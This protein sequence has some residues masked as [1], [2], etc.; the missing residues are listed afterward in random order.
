MLI[1]DEAMSSV[2]LNSELYIQKALKKLTEGRTCFIIAHRLSTIHNA[3]MI[4]VVDGGGIV[5]SGSHRELM[6]K[7]GLY[8]RMYES[9]ATL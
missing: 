5:E 4:A 2:D 9:M 6:N 7:K 8:F 1:L 3:D